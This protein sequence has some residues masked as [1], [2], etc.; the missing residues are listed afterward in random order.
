MWRFNLAQKQAQA[1]AALKSIGCDAAY[2]F[3]VIQSESEIFTLREEPHS[4]V[5]AF[6]LTLLGPDFFHDVVAVFATDLHS[7]HPQSP[8]E[9]AQFWKTAA[10]FPK[11]RVLHFN[12][13]W[14][15]P[16][17]FA[18]VHGKGSLQSIGFSGRDFS[19][20]HLK[21]IGSLSNLRELRLHLIDSIIDDNSI[22]ELTKLER[23]RVFSISRLPVGD[24]PNISDAGIKILCGC[25]TLEHVDLRLQ[26]LTDA[27]ASHLSTLPRL[28]YVSLDY[29]QLTDAGL[30][31]FKDSLQLEELSVRGTQVH[32]PG[33]LY[34]QKL[35]HF[36]S[37]A[38]G[39]NQVNDQ[40]FE[41]IAALNQIESLAVDRTLITDHGLTEFGLPPKLSEIDLE[42]TEVTDK[43]LLVLAKYPSLKKV[44]L[45]WRTI[46]KAGQAKLKLVLPNCE[47]ED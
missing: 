7:G 33:L 22:T 29:S 6:L 34:L 45:P 2:D 21:I 31:S 37:L 9:V 39:G 10:V 13:Y 8:E 18:R 30:E 26:I 5:P 44:R 32:G 36:R 42:G 16:K 46:S 1:V 4:P 20:E 17:E 27:S 12:G 38:L 11:L 28:R 19:T 47:I 43:A 14:G 41:L 25:K 23:L 40:D 35:P 15:D 3:E 24:D